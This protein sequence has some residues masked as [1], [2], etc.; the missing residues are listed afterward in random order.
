MIFHFRLSLDGLPVG[1]FVSDPARSSVRGVYANWVRPAS[2]GHPTQF[3]ILIQPKP[4]Q[5]P[6]HHA[7]V[8]GAF[9]FESSGTVLHTLCNWA[10]ACHR[11]VLLVPKKAPK[12]KFYL[13]TFLNTL[14]T[15]P[16]SGGDD[17]D[18]D[19]EGGGNRNETELQLFLPIAVLGLIL[20]WSGHSRKSSCTYST[21][22]CSWLWLGAQCMQKVR[23]M[24]ECNMALVGFWTDTERARNACIHHALRWQRR[25]S[26][27]TGTVGWNCQSN[28]FW[29]ILTMLRENL[30]R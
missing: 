5:T 15:G 3:T 10:A 19:G 8:L 27:L 12:G 21:S 20:E 7:C 11:S 22:S 25:P 6:F 26:S 9:S 18:D 13:H 14:A 29:S 28:Q 17:V 24:Q 23:L 16:G 4:Q 2:P 30:L 1:L